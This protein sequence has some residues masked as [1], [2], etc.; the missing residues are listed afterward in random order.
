MPIDEEAVKA[1]LKAAFD[2]VDEDGDGVISAGDLKTVLENAGLHPTDDQVE[3][4]ILI[5]MYTFYCHVRLWRHQ[6]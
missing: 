3:V 2:A 1:K 4:F 5:Y 6:I